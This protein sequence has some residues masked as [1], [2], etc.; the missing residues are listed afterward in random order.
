MPIVFDE[1]QDEQPAQPMTRMQAAEAQ[2]Q[3][4][5]AQGP[6]SSASDNL[7][8]WAGAAGAA[9]AATLPARGPN[10]DESSKIYVPPPAA[11]SYQRADEP[12]G[13]TAP[14]RL[15]PPP[16][17]GATP[18]VRP[19][20]TPAAF[21]NQ[22]SADALGPR[23]PYDARP[24]VVEPPTK[25]NPNQIPGYG[26]GAPLA[27]GPVYQSAPTGSREPD[28]TAL[29]QNAPWAAAN[30]AFD[31]RQRAQQLLDYQMRKD[32]DDRALAT[33]AKLQASQIDLPNAK[34]NL[35]IAKQHGNPAEVAAASAEVARLSGLATGPIAAGADMVKTFGEQQQ[36][37]A[38][39]GERENRAG[40]ATAAISKS[41][42]E[43]KM[44]GAQTASEKIKQVGFKIDNEGKIID[45]EGKAVHTDFIRQQIAG[46]KTDQ[47]AKALLNSL[48]SRRAAATNPS[49][50]A[51][52][53]A[54]LLA[55][56]GKAGEDWK[57]QHMSGGVAPDPNNPGMQV[58]EPDRAILWNART[59]EM[60]DASALKTT[61][62]PTLS[63][64]QAQ[65]AAR[66]AIAQGRDKELVNA[67]L[68]EMGHPTL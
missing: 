64:D 5:L 56:H 13:I 42:A 16:G 39:A 43:T 26:G 61:K 49:E 59:G 55:A 9:M 27:Q 7:E 1:K 30:R 62:T 52:L 50:I 6:F 57:V 21:R 65:E 46:A 8:K 4:P 38:T 60:V 53:D 45:N 22:G 36:A 54:A 48:V 2:G 14:S 66:R 31:D 3:V 58:K 32:V 20:V 34:T 24:Q 11:G 28:T 68:R 10:P 19:A 23:G 25:V 51:N 67:R 40:L 37:L 29:E 15:A 63:K 12:V 33:T 44:I 41:G 17:A 18:D 47:E 35:A